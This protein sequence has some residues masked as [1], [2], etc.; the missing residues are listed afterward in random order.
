MVRE[1]I[2]EKGNRANFLGGKYLEKEEHWVWPSDQMVF[3][4]GNFDVAAC[5]EDPCL[6]A[7]TYFWNNTHAPQL[8]YENAVR[9]GKHCLTMGKLGWWQA[10]HCYLGTKVVCEAKSVQGKRFYFEKMKYK[11]E[12]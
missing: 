8:Y 10:Y 1:L 5:S 7:K 6:L 3:F 9:N 11:D 2:R 12:L 4:K